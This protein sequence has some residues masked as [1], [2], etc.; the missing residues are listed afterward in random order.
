MSPSASRLT[1]VQDGRVLTVTFNRPPRHFFDEAMSVA[2][3]DV[4]RAVARDSTIGAVIFTGDGDRF[5]THF[6]VP[7]LLR[8]ARTI[9]FPVGYRTA[10]AVA[11]AARLATASRTVDRTLRATPARDVV[12]MGRIYHSLNRLNRMDKVVIAEI[13]GLALGMGCIVALACDIRL[14]ADDTHIGLPETGLAFLAGAGGTQ[15]LTHMIGTSRALE[16]LLDGRWLTAA[17]A[18]DLGLVHEV[19]ARDDLSERAHAVAQ[20]L[21]R[22]S[23]V[24]IREIK[25]SVYDAATRPMR[26]GLARE[27]ASTI[28]TLSASDAERAM[29]AFNTHLSTVGELTDDA[30]LRGWHPL[31]EHGVPPSDPS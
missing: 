13:N 21:A 7:D 12:F 26:S 11:G 28:T 25:R 2:F 3:D 29:S 27:A 20:R 5:I 15:R 10:R 6:D 4:T 16:L 30:I 22:R 14:M 31:L 8:G 24:S 1:T 18:H 17:Q 9:P 23:P 19:V